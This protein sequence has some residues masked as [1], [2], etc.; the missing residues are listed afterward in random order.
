MRVELVRITIEV[1]QD[2]IRTTIWKKNVRESLK[3]SV[4]TEERV[5][6]VPDTAGGERGIEAANGSEGGGGDEAVVTGSLVLRS[7]GVPWKRRP[8]G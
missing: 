3:S 8:S 1:S 6:L 5:E 7:D 2:K 4:E